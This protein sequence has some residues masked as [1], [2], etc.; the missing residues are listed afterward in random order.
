LFV[1]GRL[2]FSAVNRSNGR[3]QGSR[4]TITEL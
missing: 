3:S 4:V 2:L 1:W